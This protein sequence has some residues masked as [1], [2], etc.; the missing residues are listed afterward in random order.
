MKICI[1]VCAAALSL[2]GLTAYAKARP[3]NTKNVEGFVLE[4]SHLSV[5][6]GRNNYITSRLYGKVI[7]KENK[8]SLEGIKIAVYDGTS[9]VASVLTEKD[10]TFFIEKL[11]VWAGVGIDYTIIVSDP[12]KKFK[13]QRREIRFEMNEFSHEEVF[14]LE[15]K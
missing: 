14:A 11:S 10:G 6:G 9:E 13:A 4:D 3:D 12:N 1:K 8:V 5:Y 15:E 2:L 7:S